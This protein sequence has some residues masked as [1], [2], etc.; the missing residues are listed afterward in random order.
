VYV[1]P[2]KKKRE[3]E[4]ERK[5]LNALSGAGPH[6]AKASNLWKVIKEKLKQ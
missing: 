2:V 4:R 6:P 5:Q 1:H 3:R